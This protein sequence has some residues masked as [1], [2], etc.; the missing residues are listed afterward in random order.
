[1]VHHHRRR[2]GTGKPWLP[3]REAKVW[4]FVASF[5]LWLLFSL[6]RNS[7]TALG[8]SNDSDSSILG[9]ADSHC[10]CKHSACSHLHAHS[11]SPLFRQHAA[12][13]HGEGVHSRLSPTHTSCLR[14]LII[15]A[16]DPCVPSVD[17]PR[18]YESNLLRHRSCVAEETQSDRPER[19]PPQDGCFS[20]PPLSG[21]APFLAVLLIPLPNQN[22]S[23]LHAASWGSLA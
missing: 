12:Y 23:R 6:W 10:K 15:S 16:Q 4:C 3:W 22:G 17:C 2:S 20:P 13:S 5:L 19:I 9:D 21:H 1:M 8:N 7:G 14:P 18:D 11:S